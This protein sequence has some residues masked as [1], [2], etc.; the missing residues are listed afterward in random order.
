MPTGGAGE[1][2][3]RQRRAST[4]PAWLQRSPTT[5][6]IEWLKAGLTRPMRAESRDTGH[7]SRASRRPRHLRIGRPLRRVPARRQADAAGPD[8]RG[9]RVRCSWAGIRRHTGRVSDGRYELGDASYVAPGA[10][11]PL[12]NAICGLLD[13]PVRGVTPSDVTAETVRVDDADLP[14]SGFVEERPALSRYS[15]WPALII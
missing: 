10:E 8:R 6:R 3:V 11:E 2:S 14:V 5:R 9:G 4:R 7:L 15:S 12:T 1:W 13:V